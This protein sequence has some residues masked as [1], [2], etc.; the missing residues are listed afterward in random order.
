VRARVLSAVAAVLFPLVAAVPAQAG[1]SSVA[2]SASARVV[3]FGEAVTLTGSLS[4]GPDCAPAQTVE[5]QWR[6]AASTDFATVATGATAGDGSFSFESSQ[7]HTGRYRA[8]L[9]GLG[10]C[11]GAV[12][13]EATVRVRSAVEA[14]L[15]SSTPQSL[16]VGVFASVE[17]ARPGQTVELQRRSGGAWVLVQRLTLDDASEAVAAPCFSFD[18]LGVIRLRVR[19]VAQDPLNVTSA[20]PVLAFE[21]RETRWMH[22]IERAIG[23]R[24]VSVAVG[25][26]GSF[27]YRYADRAPRVPASNVKLLLSM[28]L[29]DTFGPDLRLRT[30]AAAPAVPPN[31]VIDDLWILGRGDPRVGRASLSSL[32]REIVA[33]GVTRIRGRVLG[34]TGYFQDDWGAPGWNDVARD[35]VNRPTA[36]AFEGNDAPEPERSAAAFLTRKLEALGIPVRGRPDSG[37]PPGRLEEIASVRSRPLHRL[38]T[39]MLRPSDNFIAEMLGK[40]LGVET[41]GVPGTIAKG[42]ASIEDWVDALGVDVTL[43][44]DSG[45]SYANRVTAEGLVRL[46]WIAEDASWGTDLREALPTGGQGTLRDRLEGTRVRAK[47]GSLTDVSALTGWLRPAGAG[48]WVEFSILSAGMP[49]AVAS[50][51][52]DEIVLILRDHLD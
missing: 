50:D 38:L 14:A 22:Q 34:G 10:A 18:D 45:L 30:I 43:F 41:R 5:L 9:P 46:L 26:G 35:Y 28:A 42:A 21:L 6:P 15:V 49:K 48:A 2:I 13:N 20:S 47:T 11:E 3:D 23:D 19:W 33:G 29:Y 51:I 36:L 31:G 16:C 25:E 1:T 44:D 24:S 12:S 37:R 8:V 17:P 40:R 32:A 27:L 52:E 39:R 4:A 7:P